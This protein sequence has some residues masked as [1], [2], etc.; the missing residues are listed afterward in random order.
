MSETPAPLR[1][2]PAPKI[3]D[4][5]LRDLYDSVG[6]AAYTRDIGQ[7]QAALAGSYLVV[8]AFAG[9]RLVGLARCVSDGVSIAYIQDIL[10]RPDHQ[11]AGVGRA[12]VSAILERV[13]HVRQ[14]VLLTD[15]RP[16]QLQFYQSLGFKNTRELL[17]TPLNAF[18]MMNGVD[19]S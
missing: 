17:A 4:E 5:A 12:L 7:L 2:E 8:A 19:L 16:E 6:W 3:G 9:D 1:I 14:K 10:V 11:R 18:V 13:A 15:D